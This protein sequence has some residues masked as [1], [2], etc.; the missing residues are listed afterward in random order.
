M[1]LELC[2]EMGTTEPVFTN[3]S[4]SLNSHLEIEELA[5]EKN[6]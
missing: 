4:P 3:S 6:I 1:D 5:E 2:Q